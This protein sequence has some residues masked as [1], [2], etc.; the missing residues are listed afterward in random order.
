MRLSRSFAVVGACTAA[1]W[2]IASG[3]AHPAPVA[4]AREIVRIR[5]H[6]DSV[7]SELAA[8]DLDR[9]TAAQ[10]DRRRALTA[11]LRTYRDRGVFPHNYDFPGRSVPY[12]VDRKTGTL[13]A[14][15]SL[16]ATTG[17]RDIVDR[18]AS[19]D[20]NI[21]VA[22]LAG[23]TAFTSWLDAHGLTLAEAARIQVPYSRPVSNGEVARQVSFVVM[24]PVAVAG[25][26]V[27]APWNAFGNEDG[28]HTRVST[29]GM[30]AGLLAGAAGGL[31]LSVPEL[32]PGV[33][34]IG[35][36]TI[37][38]G[39]LSIIA[40]AQAMLR[41]HSSV[42]AKR[43]AEQR[44][45]MASASMAPLFVQQNGKTGVGAMVALHF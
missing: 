1:L 25:A 45:R 30:G 12:F 18:V 5:A 37:G 42:V 36:A 44:A 14:V 33:Q 27:T 2:S 40:S 7:L 23:D 13:C 28:H 4:E 26:L 8:R 38:V 22:E 29:I 20:N 43:E 10:R 3:M 24:A 39:A 35:V 34:E 9:L 16:L 19:V 31:L 11:E 17:R 41:H 6:F 15:A 21:W 32:N